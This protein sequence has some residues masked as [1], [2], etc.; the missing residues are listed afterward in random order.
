MQTKS[1]LLLNYQP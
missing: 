1:R